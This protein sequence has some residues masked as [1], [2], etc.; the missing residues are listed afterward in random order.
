MKVRDAVLAVALSLS[1]VALRATDSTKVK[2]T[3]PHRITVRRDTFIDKNKDGVNDLRSQKERVR[4]FARIVKE[5]S[6]KRKKK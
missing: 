3:V 2:P 4:D 6:K 1:P 5:H